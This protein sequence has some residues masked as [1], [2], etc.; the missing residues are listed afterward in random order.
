MIF[1]EIQKQIFTSFPNV[2]L[3]GGTKS[4]VKIYLWVWL[5]H[6]IESQINAKYK[7]KV[8]FFSCNIKQALRHHIFDDSGDYDGDKCIMDVDKYG[9]LFVEGLAEVN[10]R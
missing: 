4:E 9:V 3:G 2:K 6:R 5:D 7:N 8:S 1:R 10:Q